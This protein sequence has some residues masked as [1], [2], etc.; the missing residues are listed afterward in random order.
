MSTRIAFA[1]ALLALPALG[2]KP[3]ELRVD[4]PIA[5]PVELPAVPPANPFARPLL[6]IPAPTITPLREKFNASLPV[7]SAA[8]VDRE[9]VCRRAVPVKAPLPGLGAEIQQAL[10][11]TTF[12]PARSLGGVVAT[13]LPVGFDLQGRIKEGQVLRLQP[14]APDPGAPPL[15]EITAMPVA[16]AA[17][18]ALPATP[19][20]TLDQAPVPKRFRA[21][22]PGRTLR[23][24]VVLLAEV[25][26]E[27]R[28]SRV[29]F[30]RCP[31]ALR[32][33][34][35]GSMAAWTFKPG[36]DESGPVTAWVELEGEVSVTLSGLAAEGLKVF[37]Q[38]LY[39]RA[40]ATPAGAPPPGG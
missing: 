39:P 17:D 29:V 9:G 26:A 40:A 19:V 4:L 33:W 13:W 12:A 38:S 5:V 22:L 14:R 11:E 10:L 24:G 31:E 21:S 36:Q 3:W 28:C 7:L 32:A 34:L 6:A 18:L 37:R 1:L 16:D 30:L 27:G 2:Q 15:P 20:E 35:L 8:Y 25:T 23:Q